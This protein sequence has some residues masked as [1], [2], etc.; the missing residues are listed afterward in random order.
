MYKVEERTGSLLGYF[1][2]LAI[3]IACFGLFG[4]ATYTVEQ[5]T[6]ELGLRKVLGASG[7]SIIRLIS[8]EFMQL[9]LI[10]SVISIPLSILMLNKYLSHYGYHIRITIGTF[11]IAL[12]LAVIVAGLAI[13]FQLISA[14]KMDPAK[15][16]KYE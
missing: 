12:L 3:L 8:G 2:S 6:R 15:S 10:A 4:L 7:L 13:T 16:L 1:S 11:L 9:L 14:I 5:R